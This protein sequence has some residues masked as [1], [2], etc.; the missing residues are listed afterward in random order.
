MFFLI[1]IPFTVNSFIYAQDTNASLSG[2]VTDSSGAIVPAANLSLTNLA[3]GFQQ[4]VV[5]NGSGEYTF[6]NLT[7]GKYTLS[8]NAQGFQ[9]VVQTG[10]ELAVNQVARTDVHLTVGKADET[11][12][13]NGDVSLINFENPTLEGGIAPQTLQ[14]LPLTISGMPRSAIGLAIMLPG[15][16]TASTGNAYNARINGGLTTGDEALLDGATMTEGFMNQSGMVSLYEDFQMSPDMVSEV[17]VLTANYPSQY[18][19]STSGQLIVQSKGGGEQFHGAAFEYFRNDAL[20]AIQWGGTSRVPDKENNYGANIGGPILLPWLHG[21]SSSRKAYF[22]FNWEGFQDHGAAVAPTLSIASLNARQGNFSNLKDASGNL[23]PLYY[24]IVTDPGNPL[25]S[26]SGQ[27]IPNNII[28]PATFAKIEDPIAQAWIAAMP[29]PTNSGEL[30]N[31][32]SPTAGQGSLTNAE[33]V[34]MTREDFSFRDSDHFYFTYWRQYSAPNLGSY[35]PKA[36]STASPAVPENAPIARLNWEHTFSPVMTNHATFGYLNRNEGYYA[37]NAGASLPK[38]AGVANGGLPQFNFSQYNQLGNNTDASGNSLTT[39]PTW[40]FN[41]VLTRVIGKHT[42]TA[43]YEWRNAGGNRRISTNQAGTFTFSQS[44]TGISGTNSGNDMLAFELGATSNANV[45]YYNVVSNYPR[46]FGSAA[47][48]GDAWRLNPQLTLTYGL[49]W[50]YIAPSIE[51][52]DHLS[53]FDPDGQNPDAVSTGGQPL[54]GRLAFAGN[55]YGSASYGARYPEEL[56]LDNISPRVGAAYSL[57]PKTVVRAGYGVYYGQAFY[58]GWGG[59][60]SLDG[61]NTTAQVSQIQV[62]NRQQPQMYLNYN[63]FAPFAPAVTS[64]ISAGADNGISPL[65]R[66]RDA[67]HRPYSS[68]W[69]L[70]IERELP[71]NL[72]VSASYVGTKG[73]HLPSQKSPI[74]VV[75]PFTGT[76]NTLASTPVLGPGGT[77]LLDTVLKA[78]YNATIATDGYDGPTVFAQNNVA[79]PFLGYGTGLKNC[80]PTLAQALTPFPQYCGTLQG[81]NEGHGNSIYHSLQARVERRFQAGLYILGSFTWSK[82]I[83]DASQTT[84]ANNDGSGG[85]NIFSPFD[86]KRLRALSEDNTPIVGSLAFVYE[87]PLGSHHRYLNSG[88]A[89]GF[90]GGWK[91]SPIYR[92][93]FGIPLSFHS[94]SCNVIGQTRQGCLPGIIPGKQVLPHGRNGFNPSKG[95]GQYINEDAFE[96]NFSQFGYTGYGAPVTNIYGPSFKNTDVSLTKDTRFGERLNFK[97]GT[98]FFNAWNNHYFVNQGGNTGASY[99]FNT[100]VGASGFGQWNGSVSTPRTIQFYGRLEF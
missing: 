39:R 100:T 2:T 40:A 73:T 8:V 76:F 86:I 78:N 64:D 15:V 50:D 38:V 18:G 91:V 30:N 23:I 28:D 44:T 75:N 87:L 63:G 49:R 51:K 62:G 16:S 22:Y 26:Y 84:Q 83:T 79:P 42:L 10:I 17:H 48:V 19:S 89:S 43:G 7:P 3:T 56:V 57:D 85:D 71:S 20:N 97:F 35:L 93:E 88:I 1:M 60:M 34:Y 53:F 52:N 29:T 13:V 96:T 55:K 12:T 67:N 9:S 68:Q 82:L 59:G 77:V 47:H 99:A 81:L 31:Y 61:F 45:T 27:Q 92:Y 58:P 41:D 4:N 6:R 36:L 24:P 95:D 65:Y 90:A 94:A 70:T 14:D 33:N 37:L 80:D 54:L 11:V 66:P 21:A 74:N 32:L 5:S 46:Q 98:N 69:N 72:F 25:Y